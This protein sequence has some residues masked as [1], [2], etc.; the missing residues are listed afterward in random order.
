MMSGFPFLILKLCVAALSS[1]EKVN[2]VHLVSDYL[3]MVC[4]FICNYSHI[5]ISFQC[6]REL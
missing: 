4:P 3:D 5:L 1:S 6:V 2:E